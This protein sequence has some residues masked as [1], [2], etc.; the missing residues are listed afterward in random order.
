[1]RG[2]GLG[3]QREDF[4]EN[5]AA[6]IEDVL[7]DGSRERILSA[8]YSVNEYQP[9]TAIVEQCFVQAGRVFGPAV[10]Y[11]LK[12]GGRP[13]QKACFQFT[14]IG[15][16]NGTLG[17]DLTGVFCGTHLVLPLMK[18]PLIQKHAR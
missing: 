6:D 3:N 2:I 16:F 10:P 17:V 13:E 8:A 18:G 11:G 14:A 7:P 1:M 5:E 9:Q 12:L 15:S 4:A